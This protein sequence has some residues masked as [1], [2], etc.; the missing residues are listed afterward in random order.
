MKGF[1]W[2]LL[3][4]WNSWEKKASLAFLSILCSVP[5]VLCTTQHS[6]CLIQSTVWCN[7]RQFWRRIS[8]FARS[9]PTLKNMNSSTVFGKKILLRCDLQRNLLCSTNWIVPASCATFWIIYEII[10]DGFIII[11]TENPLTSIWFI[12]QQLFRNILS[13]QLCLSKFFA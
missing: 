13:G 9:W 3:S 7:N 11:I 5:F 4:N 12:E 1:M 8:Y 6:F 2:D 10:N